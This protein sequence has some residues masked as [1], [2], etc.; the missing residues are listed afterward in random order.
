MQ[1]FMMEESF[2]LFLAP[3]SV[4]IN[5]FLQI[6]SKSLNIY[7]STINYCC[8]FIIYVEIIILKSTCSPSG[9]Q[10][11][12]LTEQLMMTNLLAALLQDLGNTKTMYRK[13]S[14]KVLGKQN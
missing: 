7:L 4:Y 11:F 10:I 9:L 13:I 6:L 12:T 5:Y 8:L 2:L 1:T 3:M 14:L